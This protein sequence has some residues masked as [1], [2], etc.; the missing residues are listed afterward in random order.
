MEQIIVDVVKRTE[1][2]RGKVKDLREG[3]FIPAVIYGEGSS[4]AVKIPSG[5]FLHLLHERRLENVVLT[6]RV[7]DDTKKSRSCL[8]KDIQYD[9]VHGHIVHLDFHEI[10]LTKM[11]KTNV[12]VVAKGESVGVKQDG[13]ALEHIMWEIE[14]EC[15]P[16]DIPK[17][18]AVDVTS[19]KIGDAVHVKDLNV[20][21]N[22]KV[23][24][25][26]D[27]TV[28]SVAAPMKEEVAPVAEEGAAPAEPEVIREKKEQP[29][30]EGKE[31]GA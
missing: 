13:G 26:A 18:I 17:E 28:L 12:P 15:L 8:I 3:G 6:L 24:S 16:T 21:S 29:A 1:T 19:L 9:P 20:P 25:D 31:E 2:G 14:V 27:A 10:S 11:I 7:K 30:A 22:V 4:Q 23:L 5:A